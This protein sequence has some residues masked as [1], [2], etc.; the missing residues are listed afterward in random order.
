M[1]IIKLGSSRGRD[2]QGTSSSN[3][4]IPSSKSENYSTIIQILKSDLLT[5]QDMINSNSG[6]IK[7]YKLLSKTPG[8]TKKL[9]EIE[10]TKNINSFIDKVTEQSANIEKILKIYG[11]KNVNDENNIIETNNEDQIKNTEIN[12]IET[13]DDKQNKSK[14]EIKTKKKKIIKKKKK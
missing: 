3:F 2:L 8:L 13:N 11:T 6:D 1:K 5:I 7:M 14:D 9:S 10:E 4:Y 12:N